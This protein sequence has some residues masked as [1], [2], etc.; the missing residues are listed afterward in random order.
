MRKGF[1]QFMAVLGL[2]AGVLVGIAL[3]QGYR[4]GEIGF[5]EA[6]QAVLMVAIGFP[7][8]VSIYFLPTVIAF[9]KHDADGLRSMLGWNAIL[10]WMPVFW[11]I[12]L[13]SA[14]SS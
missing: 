13:A 1:L 7:I 5:I 14:C 4:Y 10:G 8:A 12:M 6:I 11:F 2:L 3:F 9:H